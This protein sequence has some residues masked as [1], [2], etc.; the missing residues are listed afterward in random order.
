MKYFQVYLLGIM[1]LLSI[2]AVACK[3]VRLKLP[4]NVEV[5]LFRG[6]TSAQGY[7]AYFYLPFGLRIAEQGGKREFLYQPY[8]SSDSPGGAIV[9]MLLTWGPTP[10]QEQQIL[11]ALAELGDSLVHLAG[12]VSLEYNGESVLKINSALFTR[13]LS[14][15][16]GRLGMPGSKTALAFHF[17]GED[18]LTLKKLLDSPAQQQKVVF[19]WQGKFKD[20]YC[21][22][23]S[24]VPAWSE[25]V[26]EE[27]LCNI[28][29]TYPNR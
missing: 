6:S 17:K 15:P 10:K 1:L 18:A 27:N 7:V 9:H 12:A 22:L 23:S 8:K 19:R 3:S 5:E 14:A 4:E 11:K 20:R 24:A 13:A 21:P 25:W 28:L 26:L 16:P 2:P 29:K